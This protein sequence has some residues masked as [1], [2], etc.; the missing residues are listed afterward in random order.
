MAG[1]DVPTAPA[2]SHLPGVELCQTG[3][4]NLSTG[5]ATFTPDDFMAAVAALDCPAMRRPVL[6]LGHDGNFGVGQAAIGYVDNLRGD[7]DWRTLIGDFAGMPGWLATPDEN[8]GTVIA[9][10]FPDRSIEGA[11]DWR[12]QMGH[13]HPF[14]ILAVSLLGAEL[15]GVGTLASLQDVGRLYGTEGTPELVAAAA[16]QVRAA[17]ST[18]TVAASSGKDHPMPNPTA[19]QVAATVTSDDVRR[20]FYESPVGSDWDAWIEEIQLDPLQIIYID[21]DEGARY[22]VPVT[23]GTGDGPDAVSFGDPVKVVIRYQDAGVA[24]SAGDQSIRFASRA[25]SRPGKRAAASSDAP[26]D[27][28]VTPPTDHKEADTMSDTIPTAGLVKA[29][30]L[31]GDVDE[32]AI[33]DALDAKIKA[34]ETPAEPVAAAAPKGD[35]TE[36]A[37]LRRE[38][39]TANAKIG[40]LVTARA[41]DEADKKAKAKRDLFAAA[42]TAGKIGGPSDPERIEFEKDYDEAPQVIE[43]I[44]ASRAAGSKFPVQ[45]SGYGTDE[46]TATDPASDDNY[47]F[48]GAAKPRPALA[49]AGD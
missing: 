34:A 14:V 8:G 1:V 3:T 20:A 26:A 7:E 48:P 12:C 39:D 15:P 33:L 41:G 36:V 29:L 30:G 37:I 17:T 35:D 22:R 31:T 11:W 47:W 13:T 21:D 45:A 49:T 5:P 2:L 18:F 40:E 6:K 25:E 24:A 27:Q 23:I 38:L 28:P 32:D 44:L 10:A 43:R 19:R 9:S 4:W 42:F 46:T 16:E